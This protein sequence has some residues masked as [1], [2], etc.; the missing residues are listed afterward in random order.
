MTKAELI[1]SLNEYND[2]DNV[3][4]TFEGA[5]QIFH[6][7]KVSITSRNEPV[8]EMNEAVSFED[9]VGLAEGCLEAGG[10]SEKQKEIL[11]EVVA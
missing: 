5:T 3:F 1:K 10:L 6:I 2:S 4:L 7:D 9:I 8:L 11:Y